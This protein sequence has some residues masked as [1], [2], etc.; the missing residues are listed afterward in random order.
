MK[1]QLAKHYLDQINRFSRTLAEHFDNH[2]L[3][4]AWPES[5]AYFRLTVDSDAGPLM[6]TNG[7]SFNI[8]ASCPATLAIRHIMENLEAA[9]RL[10]DNEEYNR[11]QC[12]RI[13][14][15]CKEVYGLNSLER[16]E[17]ITAE[18]MIDFGKRF[19][20]QKDRIGSS[21]VDT[22]L[23]VSM[24]FSVLNDGQLCVPFNFG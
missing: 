5:L 6:L 13:V 19:L 2:F 4:E 20:E 22:D 14:W 9:K 10:I 11:D 15:Q 8:P 7:G 23:R 16:D 3:P 1:V 18:Q 24:Y 17:N 21:L 12:S